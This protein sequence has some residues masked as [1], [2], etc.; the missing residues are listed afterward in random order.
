MHAMPSE[1]LPCS[2]FHVYVCGCACVHVCSYVFRHCY[3]ELAEIQMGSHINK[4]FKWGLEPKL[5]P[6]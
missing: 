4:V 1:L 3:S 6:F 2:F 5:Q